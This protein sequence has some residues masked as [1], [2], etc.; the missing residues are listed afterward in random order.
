MS[1]AT[2]LCSQDIQLELLMEMYYQVL[3]H[4]L[5]SKNLHI[6]AQSQN[7]IHPNFKTFN[8]TLNTFTATKLY[9]FLQARFTG[10]ATA[11]LFIYVTAYQFQNTQFSSVLTFLLPT[12]FKIYALTSKSPKCPST[13]IS[14]L[15][16]FPFPFTDS[17]SGGIDL[18]AHWASASRLEI[19]N[20]SG[21]QFCVQCFSQ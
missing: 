6:V 7:S 9:I 17:E 3:E 16:R 14:E 11:R 18:S 2:F 8:L 20:V 1:Q 4:C 21:T 15:Q 12:S 5:C 10:S 13:E 19:P